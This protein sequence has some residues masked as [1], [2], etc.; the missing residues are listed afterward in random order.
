L[1]GQLCEEIKICFVV[2][3]SVSLQRYNLN[4][5]LEHTRE[6]RNACRFLIGKPKGKRPLG[7]LCIDGRIILTGT[8]GYNR[9]E[10][11]G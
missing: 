6:K 10:C 4:T 2:P 5:F 1:P 7:R 11:I 8:L 9:L 3:F